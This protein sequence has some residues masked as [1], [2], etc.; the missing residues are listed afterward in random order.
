MGARLAKACRAGDVIAL[1]G[2][3]AAGKTTLARSLVRFFAGS[4]TDVPSPTF[5]LVQ[6]YE[7]PTLEIWHFDL[8]RLEMPEEAGELGLSEAVDG[9]ALI[10]WPQRLG[11][12]LPQTRLDVRLDFSGEGRIAC[13]TDH[14]DWSAR[15]DG[16]WR[17][18][19]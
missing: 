2:D 12:L 11:A 6:T 9:L 16:D 19:A 14:H 13:L 1:H 7:T 10:E 8:Y 17:Q 4:D 15:I 3:L 18:S 5:T